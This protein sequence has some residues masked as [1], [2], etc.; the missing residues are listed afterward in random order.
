MSIYKAYK[1]RMYPSLEKIELNRFLENSRII[2]III[3]IQ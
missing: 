1:V 2:Y 3:L